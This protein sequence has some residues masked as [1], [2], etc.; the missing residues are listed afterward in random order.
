M[1]I[2][3]IKMSSMGDI[4]HTLPAITD[5]AK[6]Y[7]QARIDWVVEEGFVE[8]A[9]DHY[10]IEKVIPIALRRWR[11]NLNIKTLKD[12]KIFFS[13]LRQYPYD[14]V[15]D[16]QGLFKSVILTR[17]VGYNKSTKAQNHGY[18]QNSIRGKHI[19]WMYDQQHSVDKKQ[20]A[21]YKIKKLFAQI[22]HYA[23]SPVID[24]GLITQTSILQNKEPYLVFLHCTTWDSKKWPIKYWQ[25]L[26]KLANNSGY[27]VVL[28]SGNQ[29]EL[30]QASQILNGAANAVAL[31]PGRITALLKLIADS[32][33]VV[34]VDT[35]LGHLAAALN[36]PGVGI[37]GAT[38][39]E[40]TG[41]LSHK[42]KNLQSQYSCSPCLSKKCNKLEAAKGVFSPCYDL[43]SPE[44]VW[45]NLQ[46]MIGEN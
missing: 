2:L 34:C 5:L 6:A 30:E 13:D 45:G 25:E 14:Y 20:H 39:S 31:E 8:L 36:I 24:Y 7:P 10:A 43:L 40:L 9:R 35:G 21:I 16:A 12:I 17:L 26:V 28:T 4:I 33:G 46:I 44:F 37:F 15:I 19:A 22:F 1:R 29:E 32:S 3:I 18:D 11:R 42:I 27:K 38:D 23:Y 41:I